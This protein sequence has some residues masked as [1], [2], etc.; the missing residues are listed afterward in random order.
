MRQ[1]GGAWSV[2]MLFKAACVLL[3]VVALNPGVIRAQQR[4]VLAFVP[5]LDAQMIL[6]TGSQIARMLEV[7]TGFRIDAMVPTSYA[8]T[9]E[10]LCA[11]RVDLAFLAPFAYVIAQRRCGA[12]VFL[13]SVRNGRP[14]HRSQILYR[15]DLTVRT[16]GDLRGKRFAF[17]DPASTSGFLFPAALIKKSTG[18]EPVRFF[19]QVLFAGGHD[20]VVLAIYQGRVDG[21]ATFGDE[22]DPRNRA[23][24]QFPDV[25]ERVKVLMYSQPIPND[26]VTFRSDVPDETKAKVAK[27]LLR[28]AET[29][30][31][32]EALLSL[33]QIQGFVTLEDLRTKHG[34]KIRTWDDYFEIIRDVARSLDINLEELIRPR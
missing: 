26:T 27:A 3:L 21:G 34:L 13:V 28:I 20:K 16:L 17:V 14:F 8:A 10:A 24:Q 22:L 6:A 33:Y 5:G 25:M 29:A 12:E 1:T 4:L 31:G 11:G 9:I 7:A 23:V 19:N 15:G 2:R 18:L 30:P 32:K